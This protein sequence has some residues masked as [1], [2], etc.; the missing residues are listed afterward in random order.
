[1]ARPIKLTYSDLEGTGE[2]V[3]LALA[4]SGTKYEDERIKFP[5]WPQ[6]KPKMP[7]GQV[8]VLTLDGGQTHAQSG[9]L[10]RWV[11]KNFSST[12]YP[13]DKLME[14]EEAIGVADDMRDSFL[15]CFYVTMRPT[16]LGH[17]EDLPKTDAGKALVEK[18][19]KDWVR[20]EL[21]RFAKYLTDLMDKNGGGLWLASP[22]G[23]T[24]ADC[25]LIPALRAMSRGNV[26][27]VSP[28][29]LDDYPRLV[30]YVKRF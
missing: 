4:L 7:Y 3:R 13:D 8:P 19:R 14:I 6:L 26:D 25:K 16:M 28:Q 10:L 9:A 11:G 20:T 27:H 23:P 29:C 30:D 15:P 2:Q 18:M 21:P 12:L 24:I 22:D 1:V 5:D 17:A